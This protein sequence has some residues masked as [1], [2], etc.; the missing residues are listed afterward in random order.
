MQEQNML[1]IPLGMTEVDLQLAKEASDP[2]PHSYHPIDKNGY[3]QGGGYSKYRVRDGLHGSRE[4]KVD[5]PFKVLFYNDSLKP[6]AL[7][8]SVGGQSIH[9]GHGVIMC[10]PHNSEFSLSGGENQSDAT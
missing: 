1:V 4:N 8:S 10:F 2:G 3:G 6:F 9:P 7:H 5:E